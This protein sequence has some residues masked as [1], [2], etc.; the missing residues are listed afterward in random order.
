MFVEFDQASNTTYDV[1][2]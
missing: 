1:T 2:L